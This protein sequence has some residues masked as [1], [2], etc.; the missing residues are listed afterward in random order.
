MFLQ[1]SLARSMQETPAYTT[2]AGN[3]V[4]WSCILCTCSVET[5]LLGMFKIDKKKPF[6]LDIITFSQIPDFTPFGQWAMRHF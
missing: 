1:K 2:L 3:F 4:V 6:P 5:T